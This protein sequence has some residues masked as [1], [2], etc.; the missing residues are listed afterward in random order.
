MFGY[1]HAPWKLKI[2][3]KIQF[4]SSKSFCFK[5]LWN[6]SLPLFFYYGRQQSLAL[7]SC[8]PSSQ[9]WAVIKLLWILDHV[10]QQ[11]VLNQSLTIGYFMMPLM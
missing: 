6:P 8:V 5:R 4:A 7:Q 2:L 10:V 9:V 3:M 11:S 1:W